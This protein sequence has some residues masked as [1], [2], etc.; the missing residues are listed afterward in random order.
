MWNIIMAT[1]TDDEQGID[2][3]F[4]DTAEFAI[5]DDCSFESKV[6]NDN[7]NLWQWRDCKVLFNNV[8]LISDSV[9]WCNFVL[10]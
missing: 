2:A 1:F 3:Q 9:A 5:L 10:L 7:Q 6:E 4:K 8:K